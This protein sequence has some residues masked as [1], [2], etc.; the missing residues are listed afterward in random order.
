MIYPVDNAIQR[1]NNQGQKYNIYQLKIRLGI[2]VLYNFV[3]HDGV[4]LFR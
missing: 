1:L 2:L 4:A 3:L